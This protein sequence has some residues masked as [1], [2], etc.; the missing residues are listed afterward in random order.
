LSATSAAGLGKYG[1]AWDTGRAAVIQQPVKNTNFVG[2]GTYKLAPRT[3]SQWR[4]SPAARSPTRA[5]RPIKWST[6]NLNTTGDGPAG[7]VVPNP[8]SGMAYPSTGAVLHPV[9]NALVAYFPALEVNRGLPLAF[10]WRSL[11]LG[12]RAF[13]TTQ[14]D[15]RRY[16]AALEGPLPL[17]K[18]FSRSGITA[19]RLSRQSKGQIAPQQRLRITPSPSPT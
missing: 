13:T 1:S 12:N 7:T 6:A 3:A 9:F 16:L 19:R 14:T 8:L 15:T 2:R 5:S 18:F 10:R 11:P 4:R 17:G